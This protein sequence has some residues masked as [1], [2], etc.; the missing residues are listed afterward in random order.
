VEREHFGGPI[1]GYSFA[2]KDHLLLTG[3]ADLNHNSAGRYGSSSSMSGAEDVPFLPLSG[4]RGPRH[5]TKGQ[6]LFD[7]GPVYL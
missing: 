7:D 4:N 5:S 3:A 6:V 2:P 1:V